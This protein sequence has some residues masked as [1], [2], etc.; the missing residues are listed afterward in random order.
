VL[1]IVMIAVACAEAFGLSLFLPLFS[2]LID[3]NN[4]FGKMDQYFGFFLNYFQPENKML[5]LLAVLIVVFFLKSTLLILHN[6][7]SAHF[8]MKLREKWSNKILASYLGAEYIYVMNEKHG[9][10]FHNTTIEPF[11]VSKSIILLLHILSKIIMTVAIF[12]MLLYVNWKATM[13][14]AAFGIIIMIGVKNLTFNYSLRFGRERLDI[15]QEEST[16]TS[17]S[18][19]AIKEIKLLGKEER[20]RTALLKK[21]RQFTKVQTR[22][23]IF[24][25]LP[26]NLL[27]FIFIIFISAAIYYIE[28][29][30]ELSLKEL[31]P[32]LGFY[33]IVGQKLFKYS[34]LI[35]SQRMIITSALPSLRL[36]HDLIYRD[37]SMENLKKGIPFEKI[38][39]DIIIK[40]LCFS[41]DHSRPVF[42]N[43]SMKIP[44]NKMT[45]LVGPSGS[46]KSTIAEIL[47]RLL[48]PESGHIRIN[49]KNIFDF[50]L[51]SWRNK[52]GYVSQEPF[53][54]NSS[55]RENILLGKQGASDRDIEEAA[56]TANIHDFIMTLENGYDTI[57]GDR[58]VKLSGGQRQRIVIARAVIRNPELII[59]D[60]ATS[61]L[62]T[63]AE[64]EVQKSINNLIGDKT[65]L[66][67]AHRL[68]TIKKAHIVYDL[69][70]LNHD[71]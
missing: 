55:I 17:E 26:D 5:V 1:F 28:F 18:V 13:I 62:D 34:T 15:N 60:E 19:E 42:K 54:F 68:S 65:I 33:M 22:F 10:M 58:G 32:I 31:L 16:I 50:N 46:G 66:V 4:N 9:V 48:T 21:M 71:I 36:I 20:Y 11:R 61:S 14:V 7:M 35:I 64:A 24:S 2:G 3:Q 51:S 70:N 39:S 56:K 40:D 44:M 37:V 38:N 41:Y 23:S 69:G 49:G 45:A 59:F 8:A 12:I 52:I 6:G 43:F 53:L 27:E 47:M 25:Q 29:S 67:I 30:P 57:V 63:K